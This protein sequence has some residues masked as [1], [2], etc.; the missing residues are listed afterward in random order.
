MLNNTLNKTLN[1]T[2]FKSNVIKKTAVLT[3]LASLFLVGCGSD[4]NFKREVEGN[5]DYL[6]S[7]TLKPLVIPK[8]VKV[9]A[10]SGDFYIDKSEF[11]GD[12]GKQLDIRPPS[13]PIPTI[14]DAFAIYNNGAVTFNV[15]LSS[16]VWERIPDSLS[17]KNISI[18]NRDNNSIKTGNAFMP[19]ADE[20]QAVQATYSIKRQLLGD[21]ETIAISI[22]S[23]NRGSDDLMSQPI[24]VQRYVVGLFNDIMD[25]VAPDSVRVVPPKAQNN[26]A[27]KDN[28]SKKPATAVSG[29]NQE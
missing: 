22:T 11:H 16:H 19:R 23:L 29:T 12:L 3:V 21:T 8:G 4:Q 27:E 20:D 24:E 10:E 14:Q 2:I 5:E 1:K 7:P 18:V 9:P 15:P 13:L 25:D 17:K 28:E 6:K 26:D